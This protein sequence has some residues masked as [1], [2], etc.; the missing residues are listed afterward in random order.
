MTQCGKFRTGAV[1]AEELFDIRVSHT[2]ARRRIRFVPNE[3]APR[4]GIA[5]QTPAIAIGA[6]I[7]ILS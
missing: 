2:A 7:D 1:H 6:P 4:G 3:H 5:D